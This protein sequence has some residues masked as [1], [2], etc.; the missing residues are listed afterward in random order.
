MCR[1]EHRWVGAVVLSSWVLVCVFSQKTVAL[2][3]SVYSSSTGSLAAELNPTL[4]GGAFDGQLVSSL[5]VHDIAGY[6]DMVGS[7][8]AL[9]GPAGLSV[10]S[11]PTGNLA[12]ELNPTLSGG[13]FDGQLLSDLSI[14]DIAG[15]RDSSGSQL[16]LFS[17]AG[18]SVYNV[19][20][21]VLA[22][23]LNPMLSGGAFDGQVLGNLS[24]HDIVGYRDSSGSQLALFS[25]AGLSV[26][27]VVTGN[28]AGQLNPTLSGGTFDGLSV[29]SLSVHNIAGYR[30]SVGSQLAL[31]E[32]TIPEPSGLV[33]MGLALAGLTG[34]ACRKR[35]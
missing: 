17:S 2:G 32:A 5:S 26:Y 28:L 33:L 20:T 16:A 27:N 19:V 24:I 31:V 22:A 15:Y 23:E 4:N 9:F 35:R 18:L 1:I 7:Q 11:S 30:D 34:Y 3:L 13:A 21:G 29:G 8:L 14:H 12:A 10:Y 6:R 25:P